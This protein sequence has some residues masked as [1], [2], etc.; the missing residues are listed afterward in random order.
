M[1]NY[2]A[3]RELAALNKTLKIP[4]VVL[5]Y[6][7]YPGGILYLGSDFGNI[8][9]LSGQ[10]AVKILINGLKPDSLPVLRQEDLGVMV[11]TKE[12]KALGIEL[13]LQLLQ[14]AKS[15]E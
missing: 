1:R 14:I 11:D 6:V 13:P 5:A 2:E 9:A 8:G 10:Q 3:T 12:M 7:K 15:V 4:G